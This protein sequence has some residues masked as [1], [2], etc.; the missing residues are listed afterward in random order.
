VS[1]SS[2]RAF[3]GQSAALALAGCAGADPEDAPPGSPWGTA[4]NADAAAA[5]LPEAV[6]P[7]GVLDLVL[8]GG[9]AAWDTFYVAPD[10]GLPTDEAPGTLWWSYAEG[11]GG[12]AEAVADC[13]GEDDLLVPFGTD[14]GGRTIHLGPFLMA[15]RRRPDLLARTR[16]VVHRHDQ[17]PHQ[18]ALPLSLCGHGF[19]SPR[20]AGTAAH[21]ERYWA[22]R[23]PRP[24][25]H[26]YVLFP[27]LPEVTEFNADAAHAI[28][29]HPGLAR[30]MPL[31]LGFFE[32]LQAQLARD[33]LADPDRHDAAVAGYITRYRQRLR[34]PERDVRARLL[35]DFEFA[36]STLARAP[37]LRGVVGD[38]VALAG[39]S[40]CGRLAENDRSA[41]GLTVATRLL[42][43]PTTPAR[44]VTALDGGLGAVHVNS[45]YDT[46][47]NHVEASLRS[48]LNVFEQL[49]NRINEPGE[50]DADKLDLD[51][52]LVCVTT[53]FGRTP[54]RE[55]DTGLDHW[56]EG[57]V[58]VLIGGPITPDEAGV[59]GA[60]DGEGFA[61]DYT[62]PTAWRAAMLQ[63]V[64]AWPF[65]DAAFDVGDL[66]EGDD[67]VAAAR[68][69][70]SRIWGRS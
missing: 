7:A 65:A 45:S 33:G 4:P 37:D 54:F 14:S 59:V 28:G 41:Q 19:G 58:Q 57:Y 44:W 40:Y 13:L 53:E 1:R 43:H 42:T 35:D 32:R 21:V 62:S 39:G 38:P 23:E 69:L 24:E 22:E 47:G 51:R 64:G 26:A 67:A 30:P 9:L 5:G 16:I 70:R 60:I 6:R 48:T 31:Q 46:H 25:P 56:P 52:H 34:S 27:D 17:A 18:T 10:L 8:V 3:L 2:R 20:M 36:R 49:A 66:D 63:A 11:P 15:L 68:L 61:T 55:G 50:D 29:Q 12:V